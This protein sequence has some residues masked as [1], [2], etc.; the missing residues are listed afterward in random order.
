MKTQFDSKLEAQTRNTLYHPSLEQDSCGVGFVA[1]ISGNLDSGG[2]TDELFKTKGGAS[3]RSA[4]P[5]PQ[6]IGIYTSL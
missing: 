1:N 4:R 5:G 2:Q 3:C 6:W